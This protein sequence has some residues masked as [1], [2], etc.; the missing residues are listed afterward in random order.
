MTPNITH[1]TATSPRTIAPPTRSTP[2]SLRWSSVSPKLDTPDPDAPSL[3]ELAEAL[4]EIDPEMDTAASAGVIDHHSLLASWTP[5]EDL[6]AAIER[7]RAGRRPRGR[8]LRAAR[9][10]F[11]KDARPKSFAG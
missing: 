6:S 3:Q 7:P 4:A 10:R 5:L 1:R 9:V 2:T 8:R 11:A